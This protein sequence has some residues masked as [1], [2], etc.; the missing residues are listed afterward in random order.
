MDAFSHSPTGFE[1]RQAPLPMHLSANGKTELGQSGPAC[2]SG[3]MHYSSLA[4]EDY[5]SLEDEGAPRHRWG[6]KQL[7]AWHTQ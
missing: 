1:T 6:K 5:F 2:I 4:H 3:Q 7:Y